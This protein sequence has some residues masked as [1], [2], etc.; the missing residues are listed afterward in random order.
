MRRSTSGCSGKSGSAPPA[1]P[2]RR[3][4]ARAWTARR[5][6]STAR[7]VGA[8]LPGGGDLPESLDG[9]R[10]LAVLERVLPGLVAIVGRAPGASAPRCRASSARCAPSPPHARA[11]LVAFARL[12][13][14]ACPAIPRAAIAPSRLVVLGRAPLPPTG[15]RVHPDAARRRPPPP[16]STTPSSHRSSSTTLYPRLRTGGTRR[17]ARCRTSALTTRSR[18]RMPPSSSRALNASS[19]AGDQPSAAIGKLHQH[20][21]EILEHAR[22]SRSSPAPPSTGETA[23]WLPRGRP[24]G[25]ARLEDRRHPRRRAAPRRASSA[26]ASKWSSRGQPQRRIGRQR[27]QRSAGAAPGRLALQRPATNAAIT[28]A[29]APPAIA[30]RGD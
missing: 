1:W 30:S 16:R 20:P 9:T 7:G 14:L 8:V 13:T 29:N 5:P 19:S 3:H 11:L 21:L 2:A 18:N 27:H 25:H 15:A 6:P 24:P 28:S 23:G 4:S 17:S 22:P 10:P 12:V 26:P